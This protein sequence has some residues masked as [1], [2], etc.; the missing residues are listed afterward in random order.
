MPQL[1]AWH[2]RS[3][4][5]SGVVSNAIAERA[6]LPSIRARGS[7]SAARS[8]ARSSWSLPA[9]ICGEIGAAALA[10][11]TRSS[12]CDGAVVPCADAAS[13]L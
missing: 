1:G 5:R 6:S 10:A 4:A 9:S 13:R 8:S 12:A 7:S 2:T 11:F 3:G